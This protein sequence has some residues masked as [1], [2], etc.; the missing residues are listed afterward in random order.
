MLQDNIFCNVSLIKD[1]FKKIV[2]SG[3]KK[4][5][6]KKNAWIYFVNPKRPKVLRGFTFS[7]LAKI[8]K[9]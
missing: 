7:N 5:K 4:K 6:K 3:K 1:Q 2:F 8:R 9:N